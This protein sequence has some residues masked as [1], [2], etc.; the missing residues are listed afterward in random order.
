MP[1][2]SSL[3]CTIVLRIH[4]DI[5]IELRR[6][7]ESRRRGKIRGGSYRICTC[8]FRSLSRRVLFTKVVLGNPSFTNPDFVPFVQYTKDNTN[9]DHDRY[10]CGCDNIVVEND[11]IDGQRTLHHEK[12]R[13]EFH[14]K[15]DTPCGRLCI[16]ADSEKPYLSPLPFRYRF[17][18]RVPVSINPV[19]LDVGKPLMSHDISQRSQGEPLGA[20]GH[21]RDEK[22]GPDNSSYRRVTEHGN[23]SIA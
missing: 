8:C 18:L 12:D 3:W 9:N 15:K 5:N 14:N 10:D 2:I 13:H 6:I 20:D 7:E 23:P 4:S 22:H 21:K 1:C 19:V 11:I 16:H 17:L